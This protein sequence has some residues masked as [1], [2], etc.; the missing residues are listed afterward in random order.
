[1][2]GLFPAPAPCR[3][4]LGFVTPP[5][6][7]VGIQGLSRDS[8]SASHCLCL[9]FPFYKMGIIIAPTR[10]TDST[11]NVAKPASSMACWRYYYSSWRSVIGIKVPSFV[12]SLEAASDVEILN[13]ILF[14]FWGSEKLSNSSKV[15]QLVIAE[16][17][18]EPGTGVS[19]PASQSC[20]RAGRW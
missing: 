5:E 20:T 18:F 12:L 8:V 16:V 15:A 13:S 6:A 14:F 7:E 1:M 4:M 19:S 17:G 11:W 2:K 3:H 10:H 9:S